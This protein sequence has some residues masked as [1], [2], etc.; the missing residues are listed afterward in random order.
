MWK[1]IENI[2]FLYWKYDFL[3]RKPS[4]EFPGSRERLGRLAK[5]PMAAKGFPDKFR[6]LGKQQEPGDSEV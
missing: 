2:D 4:C 6:K 1:I 5:A 3:G